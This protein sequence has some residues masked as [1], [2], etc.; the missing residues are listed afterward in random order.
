MEDAFKELDHN[1]WL[2]VLSGGMDSTVATYMAMQ[3]AKEVDLISFNYGQRHKK[4][5]DYALRTSRKH[6]LRLDIV[7]LSSVPLAGSALLGD[8]EVPHGHYAEETMKATVVPNRNSMML[9]IAAAVAISRGFGVIMTGVHSG[10]HPIYPDCR[11]EFISKLQI[12]LQVATDQDIE[13]AAPFLHLTKAQIAK[14][15]RELNVDWLDTWSCYEGGTLHCGR[16]STCVERIE[17]FDIAQVADPTDYADTEY[18]QELKAAGK[19]GA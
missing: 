10:D 9:N 4:E 16:C 2:V 17:A 7:D 13:V 19:V 5:L 3:N 6:D 1:K 8:I 11:P 18:Y 14:L 12:L 15:G